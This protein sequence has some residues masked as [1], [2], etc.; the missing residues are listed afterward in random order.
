MATGDARRI[1]AEDAPDI[2]SLCFIAPV[3]FFSL[4]R[5][6]IDTIS[7]YGGRLSFV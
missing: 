6:S 5:H 4:L 7:Q 2:L 3:V 1:A